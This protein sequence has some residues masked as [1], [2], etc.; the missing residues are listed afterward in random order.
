MER[1]PPPI[2]RPGLEEKPVA[3]IRLGVI[4][5]I[6]GIYPALYGL[7]LQNYQ[8]YSLRVEI[9]ANGL[10]SQLGIENREDLKE[11]LGGIPKIQQIPGPSKPILGSPKSVVA[12]FFHWEPN[13]DVVDLLKDTIVNWKKKLTTEDLVTASEHEANGIIHKYSSKSAS[14][15]F[16]GMLHHDW[17]T[18]KHD[19]PPA[20]SQE[21][22][23]SR[24]SVNLEG[25]DLSDTDLNN[26]NLT[27][28][29]LRNSNFRGATL[30][31]AN[32][33][34][35][36]WSASDLTLADLAGSDLNS[37]D[38][39]NSIL[40]GVNLTEVDLTWANLSG[41]ILD[42]K[43]PEPEATISGLKN[44]KS[45]QSVKNTNVYGLD[46]TLP[47]FFNWAIQREAKNL[48]PDEWEEFKER[49][50]RD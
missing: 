13:Q 1:P 3:Q 4:V 50:G 25:I 2:R 38:L 28:A 39:S 5:A 22:S 31:D 35:I 27:G 48:A 12:S 20:K 15:N 8:A 11:I 21:V 19:L 16:S 30:V 10:L 24:T 33:K 46:D 32:L 41:V 43:L 44:W 7:A 42:S 23:V 37:S 14:F 49:N 47:D 45:I 17:I 34:E 29:R 18:F 6:L 40:A 36:D 26:A 9:R